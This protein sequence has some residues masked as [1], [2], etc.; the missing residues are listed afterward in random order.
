MSQQRDSTQKP[1]SVKL[2]TPLYA[3]LAPWR[4]RPSSFSMPYQNFFLSLHL[5]F[6]PDM[7]TYSRCEYPNLSASFVA[8]IKAAGG[9][10]KP[11]IGEIAQSWRKR[12]KCPLTPNETVLMLQSLRIPTST[13]IY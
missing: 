12:G 8:A 1:R 3:S 11:W 4:R 10:K 6:E 9:D 13:N 2:V 5:R 7:V